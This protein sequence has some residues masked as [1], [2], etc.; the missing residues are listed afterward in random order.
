MK[1]RFNR[2]YVEVNK[3]QGY[4]ASRMSADADVTVHVKEVTKLMIDRKLVKD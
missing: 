1:I 2:T 3:I 4:I